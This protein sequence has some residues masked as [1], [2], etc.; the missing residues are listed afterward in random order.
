MKRTVFI[1]ALLVLSIGIPMLAE[2]NDLLSTELENPVLQKQELKL[3]WYKNMNYTLGYNSD[4][5]LLTS[6]SPSKDTLKGQGIPFWRKLD[7][8]I[9]YSG[10]LCYTGRDL[11][12]YTDWDPLAFMNPSNYLYYLNSIEVSAIY[13]LK[14]GKGIEVGMGY[15]WAKLNDRIGWDSI[16]T[17]PDTTYMYGNL[18]G[19]SDIAIKRTHAFIGKITR[20]RTFGIEIEYA[21]FGTTEVL[22][23]Y[24]SGVSEW[25]TIDKSDVVRH[26]IGGGIYLFFKHLLGEIDRTSIF[27]YGGG[28]IAYVFEILNNSP[29]KW[30]G[31]EKKERLNFSGLYVGIKLNFGGLK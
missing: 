6:G 13:P 15:G 27:L 29:F 5:S 12:K 31:V 20:N 7:Y 30:T 9:G 25:T 1:V 14:N 16:F 19:G 10:G 17:P 11:M 2:S 22:S 23:Y 4:S 28:K 3:P 21:N 8:G 26:C 24:K 18:G